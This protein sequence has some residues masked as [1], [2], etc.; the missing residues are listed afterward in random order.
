MTL[1]TVLDINLSAMAETVLS[2]QQEFGYMYYL[3]L[4]KSNVYK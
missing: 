4:I 1:P 2:H 3:Q